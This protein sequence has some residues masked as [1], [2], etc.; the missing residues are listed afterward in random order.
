MNER[1]FF[2][3][4]SQPGDS[5]DFGST[6]WGRRFQDLSRPHHDVP[7]S[8]IEGTFGQSGK[9]KVRVMAGLQPTTLAALGGK[10]KKGD[11]PAASASSEPI[12]VQLK[13]KRYIFDP[14]KQM[15]QS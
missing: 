3:F 11:A 6:P 10:K 4:N 2:D 9:V 14:K 15:I 5:D 13:F 12:R 7:D 1:S 8:V